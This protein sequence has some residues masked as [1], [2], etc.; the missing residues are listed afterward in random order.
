MP[1]NATSVSSA[2]R[3]SN[4]QALDGTEK[5]V[6]FKTTYSGEVVEQVVNLDTLMNYI[7]TK[8]VGIKLKDDY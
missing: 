2:P 3:E 1:I 7:S 8:L 6:V 5:F 4:S